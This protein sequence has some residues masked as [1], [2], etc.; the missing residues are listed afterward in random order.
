MACPKRDGADDL[1]REMERLRKSCRRL[2]WLNPLLRFDAFE[3]KALGI[4]AMLPFV[5][6]FRAIHNLTSMAQLCAVL[7][8]GRAGKASD[9]RQW[10]RRA[11]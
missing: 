5:D 8:T 6:E 3:A 2:V 1:A 7:G 10:L 9:P 4:R 11:A